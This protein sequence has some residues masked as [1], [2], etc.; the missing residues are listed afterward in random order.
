MNIEK[1]K[2]I[3][4]EKLTAL[5]IRSKSYWD[6]SSE[7]MKVWKDELTI[8]SDYIDCNEVY[9]LKDKKAFIGYYAFIILNDKKVKLDNIFIEPKYIGKGYG[10]HLMNNFM[11]QIKLNGFEKIELDSDPN[12]VD[13][14]KKFGFKVVGQLASSIK[15]RFLAIMTLDL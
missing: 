4:A 6:Y 1:A 8:S 2:K 3:D 7:Q 12:A 5:T 10:K 9:I 13:F 15:D 11:N 14:Y